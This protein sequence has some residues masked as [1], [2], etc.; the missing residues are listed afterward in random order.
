MYFYYFIILYIYFGKFILF[1]ITIVTCYLICIII[2]FMNSVTTNKVSTI[3][4]LE[5]KLTTL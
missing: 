2:I 4:D 5:K 1:E 3:H